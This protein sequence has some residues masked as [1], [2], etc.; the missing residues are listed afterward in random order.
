VVTTKRLDPE[1]PPET[2][3]HPFGPGA[4]ELV[5]CEVSPNR[6][7]FSGIGAAVGPRLGQTSSS[8][9]RQLRFQLRE[10]RLGGLLKV[11]QRA[12]RLF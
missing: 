1:F 2:A 10:H 9:T 5:C 11:Y 8:L 7:P 6:T 3:Q 4:K 12:A